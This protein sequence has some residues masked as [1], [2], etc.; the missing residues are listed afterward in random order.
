MTL[1]ILS[2]S[3][4]LSAVAPETA[5]GAEQVQLRL[6]RAVVEAGHRSLVIAP[7]G[8]RVAGQLIPTELPPPPYDDAAQL[9]GQARHRAAVADT[10]RRER[11]D[12]VHM[13][14]LDFHAYLPAPGPPVLATLH[15]PL[16][17]YP[18]EALRPSRP[19]TW[20][21]CVSAAQHA[22]APPGI[23]LLPPIENGVDLDALT[24]SRGARGGYALVLGRICPE[25]GIHLAVE[26]ARRAAIP[27]AIAGAAYPYGPH[28]SYF[29]E[30][31]RPHLG[32]TCRH[33][34][35][36][37][38]RAK[39]RLLAR[40]RCLLV[41]S[42]APETSSLVA[43]EAAACGTPVIAFPNGALADAVMDGVTGFL[44]PDVDAMAAAIGH[45]GAIDPETCRAHA[46]ARFC[47]RDMVSA[48]LDLYERLAARGLEGHAA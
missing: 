16:G 26:A 2:V 47:D 30:A 43:R 21:H 27:L 32:R 28:L 6:D 40:A 34:G 4:P 13:H 20:L 29:D 42:L 35:A 37:G 31:V 46:R 19:G 11:V 45:A 44:V 24:P 48:Y 38:L 41:P 17:W 10:I 36:L 39:R 22:S 15:L 33:L 12:L 18:T 8:S 7:A 1:T 25:K 14:G 3:Y 23:D 5:G 9:C